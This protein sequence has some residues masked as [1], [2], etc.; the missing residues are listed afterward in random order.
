[1]ERTSLKYL[2]WGMV[3]AFL[4]IYIGTLNLLPDFA[5][6]LLFYASIQSHDRQTQSEQRLKPLFLVLAADY[7]LHW[8]WNFEN[9]LE[10][11]LMLIIYIYAIYV[12]LGE[13]AGRIREHQPDSA[14]QISFIR[15]WTILL[16]L[17]AFL[18]SP[19]ENETVNIVIAIVMIIM[20]IVLI[21]IIWGIPWEEFR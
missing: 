17:A 7:F 19:Y 20:L 11:L 1:M 4:N 12:L 21:V 5:G 16:Q 3:F 2:K 18:I 13:V 14:K 9:H 10:S 8:I 15:G 6:M